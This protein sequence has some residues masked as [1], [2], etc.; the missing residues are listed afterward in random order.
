MDNLFIKNEEFVMR[1]DEF[2]KD[3]EF[4]CSN[5]KTNRTVSFDNFGKVRCLCECQAKERDLKEEEE[6]KLEIRRRYLDKLEKIGI[7]YKKYGFKKFKIE[8]DY[9]KA[10]Y[11]AGMKF[12]EEPELGLVITGKTGAG[13]T[14][15]LSSAV[16]NLIMSGKQVEYLKWLQHGRELKAVVNNEL[17]YKNKIFKYRTAKILYIDDFLKVGRNSD[18]TSADM[19]LAFDI[20]DYRTQHKLPTIISSERSIKEIAEIDEAVAGR[21]L[22]LCSLRVELKNYCNVKNYRLNF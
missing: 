11:E 6:R 2:E 5:C 7:N 21:L 22:E 18:V 4:Y 8:S 16:I 1:D 10:M 17:E 20:L 13:K 19:T 14:H 9:Q 3:G 15:I 12:Y